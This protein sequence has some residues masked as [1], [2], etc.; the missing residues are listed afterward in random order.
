MRKKIF[1]LL[2]L[3]II[4]ASGFRADNNVEGLSV[5]FRKVSEDYVIS[6]TTNNYSMNGPGVPKGV[7]GTQPHLA[8]EGMKFVKL[9]LTLRNDGDKD[10]TF[11]F[12]DVYISTEQDTLYPFLTMQ[13]Y[14]ARTKIKIKP[15]KEID[16]IVLFEFPDK[17]KP[18]ELFIEDRRYPIIEEK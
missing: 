10:C 3:L 11:D 1:L 14:F 16:R 5:T 4:I 2:T 8:D 7:S 15:H 6:V 12:A 18:K 13:T 17:A 9:K